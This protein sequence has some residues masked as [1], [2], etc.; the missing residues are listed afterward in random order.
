MK[1]K[2]FIANSLNEGKI[3][4]KEELGEDAIILSN[5]VIKNPETGNDV[6]EIVAAIDDI[7]LKQSK[8][9]KEFAKKKSLI[10]NP[11]NLL[12]SALYYD[13]SNEKILKYFEQLN[14][15]IDELNE[16]VKFKYS[17][18]LGGIYSDFYKLLRKNEFDDEYALKLTA[19]LHSINKYNNMYDLIEE[20][21][22][23]ITSEI[24]LRKGL[25]KSSNRQISILVGPTGSGKTTTSV[26]LAV[27]TKLSYNANVLIVSADTY[28]V[29]GSEQLQTFAS[30]AGIPFQSVFSPEDLRG[31]ISKELNYDFIFIDTIGVSP[32]SKEQLNSLSEFVN[33]SKPEHIFLVQSATSSYNN[34]K[35]VLKTFLKFGINGLILTKVDEIDTISPLVNFLTSIDLPI[36]YITNGQ[37]IPQDIELATKSYLGKI[38]ISEKFLSE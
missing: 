34:F 26:K 36:A 23:I 11:A 27:M 12:Q 14:D 5:R 2:K 25:N 16:Y 30:I 17:G 18:S 32:K 19:K 37:K 1:I 24:P 15:K 3:R 29:G 22:R 10:E 31:L 28:K 33:A 7:N 21:R 4:I 20:A 8:V 35:F 38:L 6:Y 9:Q 13:K